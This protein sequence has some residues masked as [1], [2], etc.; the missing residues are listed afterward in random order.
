MC[1]SGPIYVA[2]EDLLYDAEKIEAASFI[3]MENQLHT[4]NRCILG[5]GERKDGETLFSCSEVTK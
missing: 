4:N 2:S 1:R 5:K 3:C